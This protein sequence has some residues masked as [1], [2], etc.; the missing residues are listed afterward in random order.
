MNNLELADIEIDYPSSD[1]EPMAE[2]TLQYMWIVM[3]Q[4][5]LDHLFRNRSDV[6]VAG[7]HLI[8]PVEG[9]NKIRCAPDIYVAFGRPKAHRGSYQVWNEGNIFP[10]VIFEILSPSNRAAEMARK[11]E[12]YS[13][14][15]AEE[16]YIY[17]PESYRFTIYLRQDDELT[18]INVPETWTSPL[19]G[20]TFH[21]TDQELQIT[22]PDGTPFRDPSETS[23][24]A[25]ERDEALRRAEEERRLAELERQRTA[26]QRRLAEQEKQRADQERLRAEEANRLAEQEKERADAQKQKADRLAAQLRALGIDPDQ[27]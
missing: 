14:Y 12:F 16:Y 17:D 26:E 27:V 9:D 6:F 25:S 24:R 13:E 3:I 23:L 7:D 18:P 19:L 2:S 20:I 11:L 22:H 5:N 10:Q 21:Q 1:G 8:Y 4:M 15:G